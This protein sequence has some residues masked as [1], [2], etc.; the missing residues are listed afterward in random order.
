[1]FRTAYVSFERSDGLECL[2]PS[3]T[4]QS[5]KEESDINSVLKKYARTGVLDAKAVDSGIYGDFSNAVTY[6]EAM[7]TVIRAQE[8]F[9][10]LPSFVRNKFR[11]DP[12]EFLAFVEDSANADEL[13]RMGLATAKVDQNVPKERPLGAKQPKGSGVEGGETP[14]P[15]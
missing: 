6:Q 13:V 2:D 15:A 11:N 5:F 10:G 7:N 8:Q 9:A 3:R 12:T 1:M 14:L 4:K